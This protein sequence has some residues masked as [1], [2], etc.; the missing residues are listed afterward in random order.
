MVIGLTDYFLFQFIG[1]LQTQVTAATYRL[2][3]LLLDVGRFHGNWAP[4]R[5]LLLPRMT[6][7]SLMVIFL[8]YV[9]LRLSLLNLSVS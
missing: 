1:V 7:L 2:G 4:N 5:E 6:S 3:M 8:H 9:P